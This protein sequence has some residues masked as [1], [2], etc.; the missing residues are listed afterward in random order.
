VT[1]YIPEA[2]DIVMM[3]FDP[4]IGR[5]QFHCYRTIGVTAE[6]IGQRR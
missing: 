5:E 2:G 6:E 1:A 3:D 4:Q